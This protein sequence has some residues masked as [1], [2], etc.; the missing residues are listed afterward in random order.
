MSELVLSKNAKI[1]VVGAGPAGIHMAASLRKR[2]YS[3]IVLLEQGDRVGGKTRSET[4]GQISHEI[5]TT[6]FECRPGSALHA[7]LHEVRPD[8]R[9]ES[10]PVDLL[11]LTKDTFY[12]RS[13]TSG[14]LRRA[15]RRFQLLAHR[16]AFYR[17]YERLVA[18]GY[19]FAVDKNDTQTLAL[20]GQSTKD[21]LLNNKLH[22]FY[23]YLQNRVIG[24]GYGRLED[25]PAYYGIALLE[26]NYISCE[27]YIIF[28]RGNASLWQAAIQ[29]Y[30]LDVRLNTAVEHIDHEHYER[31]KKV[32][33]TLNAAGQRTRENY[34][35]AIITTPYSMAAH[36]P[37]PV[38]ACFGRAK[39]HAYTVTM[40]QA[41]QRKSYD[42]T[43]CA[44]YST[45]VSS[46]FDH[47]LVCMLNFSKIRHMSEGNIGP[48]DNTYLA[49]QL[50]DQA[51]D[52]L[53]E[54]DLLARLNEQ[55]ME[56]FDRT[57]GAHR[58][59]LQHTWSNY[60]P[61]LPGSSIQAGDLQRI[62]AEQGKHGLW[63]LGSSISGELVSLVLEHN[64]H[65][66]RRLADTSQDRRVA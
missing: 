12:R 50:S 18:K 43:F 32:A 45:R 13:V 4:C 62:E 65:I 17:A 15:H 19:P 9:E 22:L 58:V 28:E 52:A 29:K 56:H 59:K 66:L 51:H 33:L 64:T 36:L 44:E 3:K 46:S 5:G 23:R 10:Y 6:S 2:G 8:Y 14:R 25:I 55:L 57:K 7:F 61:H 42:K 38:S 16:R 27:P 40:L 47:E 24:Y 31:T 48:I 39:S 1:A 37:A 30:D 60:S 11:K 54:H 63:Y 35:L 21:F 34:D 53:G 20:L 49:F 41:D 26:R